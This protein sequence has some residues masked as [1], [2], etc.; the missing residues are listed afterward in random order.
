[1]QCSLLYRYLILSLFIDFFL[2]QRNQSSKRETDEGGEEGRGGIDENGRNGER[3][4]ESGTER[5]RERER[6]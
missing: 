4:R 6:E 5:E 1:M 2:I 3:E